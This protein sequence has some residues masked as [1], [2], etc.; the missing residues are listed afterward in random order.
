[1]KYFG[2]P[3]GMWAL[4]GGSFRRQLTE[5]LGYDEPTAKTVTKAAGKKY[6]STSRSSPVFRNLRRKTGFR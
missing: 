4:F 5:T 6:G 1:M 2:M 3:M